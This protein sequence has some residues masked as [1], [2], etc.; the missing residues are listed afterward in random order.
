MWRRVYIENEM[1][2]EYTVKCPAWLL[3]GQAVV[4]FEELKYVVSIQPEFVKYPE[5]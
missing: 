1:H 2:K 5:E 4:M 3:N